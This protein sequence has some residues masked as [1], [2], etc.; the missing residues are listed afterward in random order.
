MEGVEV[1]KPGTRGNETGSGEVACVLGQ[2][3][4][5]S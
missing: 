2:R 5:L 3:A 1:G 4:R